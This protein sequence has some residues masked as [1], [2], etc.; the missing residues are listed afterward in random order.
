MLK[1]YIP[2]ILLMLLQ[3]LVAIAQVKFEKTHSVVELLAKADKENKLIFIDGYTDW[4]GWCK[5]LDEKVFCA[6]AVADTMNK[7]FVSTKLEMEKD[8][9]GILLARKYAVMGFP[10]ALILNK[11]GQLIV[12]L[13]GYSD[14]YLDRIMPIITAGVNQP[15]L[16]GYSENIAPDFPSFYINVF[17]KNKK[18]AAFP[19]SA[20]V[21]AFLTGRSD[22]TDEVSWSVFKRFYFLVNTTQQNRTLEN[23]KTLNAL[24]GNDDVES[25]FNSMFSSN[26][27]LAIKKHDAIAFNETLKKGQIYLTSPGWFVFNSKLSQL[28]ADSNWKDMVELITRSIPDTTIGLT[29]STLNQYAWDLYTDCKDKAAL[30]AAIKWMEDPVLKKDPQYA[31]RDTYAALLYKTGNYAA[32]KKEAIKAI[33]TGKLEKQKDMSETEELVKKIDAARLK[34]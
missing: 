21:N 34:N 27:R 19:D 2:F 26:I 12:A 32:A 17:A 11:K 33:E 10:T 9:I 29:P 23:A 3:N 30:N 5:V 28:K 16:S 22:M 20:T 7:Y 6:G 15:V 25:V 18:S 13:Q 14:K 31:H 8:S 1:K 24:F 4:C